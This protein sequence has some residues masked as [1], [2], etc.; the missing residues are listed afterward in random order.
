MENSSIIEKINLNIKQEEITNNLIIKLKLPNNKLDQENQLLDDNPP[1]PPPQQPPSAAVRVAEDENRV[2]EVKLHICPSCNKGFK[3]AKALDG[4]SKVHLQPPPSAAVCGGSLAENNASDI[5]VMTFKC[6]YCSREFPSDKSLYGHMKNHPERPYRGMK[7]PPHAVEYTAPEVRLRRLSSW[8]VTGKRG[9][10]GWFSSLLSSPVETTSSSS[11]SA[12]THDEAVAAAETLLLLASG[13]YANDFDCDDHVEV[14][15]PKKNNNIINNNDGLILDDDEVYYLRNL[16]FLPNYD[17][18]DHNKCDNHDNEEDEELIMEVN[19]KISPKSAKIKG[20]KKDGK[21]INH[22]I[23]SVN[24][25]SKV[26]NQVLNKWVCTTCGKSFPTHQALG[27]HRSSHNKD[28]S[29]NNS[30]TRVDFIDNVGGGGLEIIKDVLGNTSSQHVL[31]D[32]IEGVVN[33]QL[34]KCKFC[35]KTFPSGQALGGHQRCH[36]VASPDYSSGQS[37]GQTGRA[38]NTELIIDLNLEPTMMD[39][40]Y[41]NVKS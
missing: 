4:H 29:N 1:L 8:R 27:G 22:K 37:S 12:D 32:E 23:K 35:D 15:K 34:H 6:K 25:D 16:G 33:T 11:T 28:K 31:N 41:G 20:I 24:L 14:K 7:E 18:D 30:Q 2:G 40:D 9:R 13:G 10:K 36:Y 5:K 19:P 26:I 3:S 39:E 38:R 17:D 21:M